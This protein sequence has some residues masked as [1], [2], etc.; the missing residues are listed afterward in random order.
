MPG[1]KLVVIYPYP[2]DVETFERKYVSDHAP[3]VTAD[4]FPGIT[5]FVATKIV[6]TPDGSQPP[7]YRVA[8]LY[9]P[10]TELL[11]Q[12]LASSGAQKAVAHAISI[13]NGGPPMV[14]I[15][16]EDVATF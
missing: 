11:E 9:F 15:A 16:A 8:E 4:A 10:S 2:K 7:F 13:S 6:G 5:K 3:M 12:A 1:M 14:L